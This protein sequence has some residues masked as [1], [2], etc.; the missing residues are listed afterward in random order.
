LNPEYNLARPEL[1][2]GKELSAT[3]TAQSSPANTRTTVSTRSF[4]FSPE[5]DNLW[6]TSAPTRLIETRQGSFQNSLNAS[7]GGLKFGRN[8]RISTCPA[9][10]YTSGF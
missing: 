5:Q 2:Y 10:S 3:C 8:P 4:D 1:V 7:R 9:A 6:A